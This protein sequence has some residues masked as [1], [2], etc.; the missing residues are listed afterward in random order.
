MLKSTSKS[1]R[2]K[3]YAKYV[4]V[5]SQNP[6]LFTDTSWVQHVFSNQII[7]AVTVTDKKPCADMEWQI[8]SC[9]HWWLNVSNTF[10]CLSQE[11]GLPDCEDTWP[12]T[13]NNKLYFL[14]YIN[15]IDFFSALTNLLAS[16]WSW[17]LS[18]VPC[19][20]QFGLLVVNMNV[21]VSIRLRANNEHNGKF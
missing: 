6:K 1:T 17:W 11:Q 4:C 12:C 5:I 20:P 2:E 18:H 21:K 16:T 14:V 19:I 7:F 15:E 8:E 9:T 10:S 3:F 13:F